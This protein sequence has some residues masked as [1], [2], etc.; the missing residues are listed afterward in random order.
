[1]GWCVRERERE[2]VTVSSLGLNPRPHDPTRLVDPFRHD[3]PVTVYP[4]DELKTYCTFQ[5]R[6]RTKTTTFGEGSLDEMCFNFM[7]YFPAENVVNDFCTQYKD[8]NKC[9]MYDDCDIYSVFN[10]T[11]PSVFA[12][13][14][15]VRHIPCAHVHGQCREGG[16]SFF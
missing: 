4:G 14:E 2:R 8:L 9:D 6:S 1:M 5:S 13:T 12:M 3:P 15:K 16:R 7:M 10:Y 11:N